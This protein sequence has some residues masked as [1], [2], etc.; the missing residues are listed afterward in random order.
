MYSETSSYYSSSD[1]EII[2]NN[3]EQ[4]QELVVDKDYEINTNNLYEIRRKG[5]NKKIKLT[6]DS[7][8]YYVCSLNRK[9]FKH[10]RVVA[11]QFIPNPEGK[12]DIDHMNHVRNDN[13]ISN[14]R[15]VSHYEN[16][17]NKC[18]MN[19]KLFGF[20]DEIDEACISIEKYGNRTLEGYYYDF[21]RDIFYHREFDG[22]YRILNVIHRKDG[23]AIVK[24]YDKNH[25]R[26]DLCVKKFLADI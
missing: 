23:R 9:T 10:H 21:N 11:I 5:T 20:T 4:W 2:E 13:N 16:M 25:V 24:M 8:G 7:K 3:E 1:S 22:K 14:L 15:W 17:Q 12:P 26:I 6:L 18:S 19:G